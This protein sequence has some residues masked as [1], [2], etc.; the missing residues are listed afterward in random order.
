MVYFLP[1]EQLFKR[2]AAS[3]HKNYFSVPSFKGFRSISGSKYIF[4]YAFFVGHQLYIYIAC[5]I[6]SEL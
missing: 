5:V 4:N 2:S 6:L 1:I 3:P